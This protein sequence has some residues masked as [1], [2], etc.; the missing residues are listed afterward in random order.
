MNIVKR[1]KY[2]I[3]KQPHR[4]TK[5]RIITDTL[6]SCLM[7][8]FSYMMWAALDVINSIWYIPLIRHLNTCI[9][10]YYRVEWLFGQTTKRL[11]K[12]DIVG[13]LLSKHTIVYTDL[14]SLIMG[15]SSGF[16]RTRE[17]DHLFFRNQ[18]NIALRSRN[19]SFELQ[20]VIVYINLTSMNGMS[21]TG[22]THATYKVTIF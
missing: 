6:S 11:F 20:T 5:Y 10:P 12:N 3:P 13:V 9:Y 17:Y 15:A 7:R 14:F 18:K 21:W 2:C 22:Y 4:M 1:K 8:Q 19:I 16:W